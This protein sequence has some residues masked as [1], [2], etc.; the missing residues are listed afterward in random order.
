M[1]AAPCKG[2]SLVEVP[3]PEGA[4]LSDRSLPR[5]RPSVNMRSWLLSKFVRSPGYNGTM[6]LACNNNKFSVNAGP[7]PQKK[8][9]KGE[10]Q[11]RPGMDRESD[12]MEPYIFY[13]G[14]ES[15][16]AL[17]RVFRVAPLFSCSMFLHAR[18]RKRRESLW[19]DGMCFR[20]LGTR[21]VLRK[22]GHELS[23]AIH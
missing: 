3:C 5:A 20:G 15:F 16:P 21:L 23:A 11:E 9:W 13:F 2:C 18:L 17:R 7:A 6:K 1:L 22:V 8:S 14:G 4:S 10:A 12:L 19:G